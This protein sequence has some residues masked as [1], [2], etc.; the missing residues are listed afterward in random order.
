MRE[1]FSTTYDSKVYTDENLL[2]K[3]R[4]ID[5]VRLSKSFTYLYGRDSDMFPLL[6]MTEA[7]NAFQSIKPKTLNDSQYTWDIMGRMKHTSRIVG[8]ANSGNVTPGRN[9]E[10]FDIDFEDNWFHAYYSAYSPDQKHQVRI[11]FEP[12][13]LPNG[14]YRATVR[15]MNTIDPADY[16]T[17]DNFLPGKAWVMGATSVT[18][19]LS[20][21]TTSN[22]MFPGK[23]TNQFGW[24]RYSKQIAGN[25]A[26][27]V[28][29][30]E[31]DLEGGGKTNLWIPFEMMLW[32]KE[33][34]TI[35]EM[36]LWFSEYN[37]DA[38]GVIHLIDDE[39]GLPVPKGAGVKEIISSFG[40]Y[41]TYGPV[42]TKEKID[43]TLFKCFDNRVDGTPTEIVLYTGTGGARMFHQ[44]IMNDAVMSNYFVALGSNV[45]SGGDYMSY[46]KYFNQYKTIDGRLVTVKVVKLFDHGPFAEQNKANS[47]YY[48]GLPHFSYTMV[49]MDHSKGDDGERNVQLVAEEGRELITGVYKGLTPLPGAWGGIPKEFLSTRK[50]MAAYEVMTSQ[51]ITIKNPT[52]SFWLDFLAD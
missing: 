29:V 11:Q 4:L 40:H 23:M 33:R 8:L 6:G 32:E 45:I 34:R 43:S 41:D 48:E 30:Y 16:V 3:H 36:D 31:F 10:S 37:R 25:V 39:N 49:F 24:Q 28:T 18:A 42:L 5:P 51:G 20:D 38:N 19:S 2:Y 14:K 44:A 46:G 22:Q 35:N 50:D 7:Q 17:L 13:R 12:K 26:N 15:L 27:K 21:G 1:L 9:F 47:Q 52:T